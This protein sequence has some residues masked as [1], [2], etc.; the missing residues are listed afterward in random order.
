LI[1]NVYGSI[2]ILELMVVFENISKDFISLIFFLYFEIIGWGQI[3]PKK[4]E[5][6]AKKGRAKIK[7]L[8]EEKYF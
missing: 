2:Y 5:Q 4:A 6:W 1:L 8:F 7:L 3:E